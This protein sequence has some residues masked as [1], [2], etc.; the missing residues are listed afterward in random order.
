MKKADYHRVAKVI[1][2]LEGH[3]EKQGS[4]IKNVVCWRFVHAFKEANSNFNESAF[5]KDCGVRP[6]DV[7]VDNKGGGK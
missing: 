2:G 4:P 7:I 6:N 3:V 1:S 5:T